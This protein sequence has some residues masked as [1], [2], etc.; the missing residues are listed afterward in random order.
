LIKNIVYTVFNSDTSGN[1]VI[2][3]QTDYYAF[4]KRL[5]NNSL[6]IN[7]Y[8][9]NGKEKQDDL[10]LEWY[11]YGARSLSLRIYFGFNLMPLLI[12]TVLIYLLKMKPQQIKTLMKNK[13]DAKPGTNP[14]FC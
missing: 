1:P 14:G 6:I 8:L 2:E 9:Y 5:I 4:I 11:D 10:G 7:K 13:Q 3:Q 12:S